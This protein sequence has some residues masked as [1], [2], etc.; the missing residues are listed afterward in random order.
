MLTLSFAFIAIVLLY[1]V[2]FCLSRLFI[3]YTVITIGWAP[4]PYGFGCF[5]FIICMIP[6]LMEFLIIETFL[7]KR[8]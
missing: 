6:L 1:G 2:W 8:K 7:F 5:T 4:G 3:L